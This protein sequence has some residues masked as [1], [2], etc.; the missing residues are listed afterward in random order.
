MNRLY[1]VESN[2][3]SFVVANGRVLMANGDVSKASIRVEDGRIASVAP[4][5]KAADMLDAAG[6]YVVPGLIDIHTHGIGREKAS[7][8]LRAYA[9]Q[10]AARG[11]TTFFPT[12]FGPPNETADHLRRHLK[13]TDLL[14]QVPQVGGFRLE[15]PYLA[16]AAGGLSRDLAPISQGLTDMLL[17][18]GEGHI[19]IWDV[20]PEMA[21]VPEA[22][23]YLTKQGIICSLA[24]TQATIDQARAA[25]DAGA[26]LVTHLFDTFVLPG[27]IDPDPG[28]YPAGL[29][30]YLLVEDRVVC[31]IIPDGTHV[32]PILVE[33]AFRCKPSA[34]LVFVT[35]SNY[36]AGLPPG[37][38]PLPGGW[39]LA[40]I[41]G[42]NNGVRLVD[43]KMG[44]CGSAL[45][46]I[47]CFRNAVKLFGK[48][49]GTASCVC[50]R[51]QSLLLGLNKGEIKAGRDADLLVLDKELNV[52]YTIV[53][54]QIIYRHGSTVHG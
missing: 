53:A 5:E 38:Y 3:S 23:R 4:H 6:A 34:G 49:F 15:S 42:P 46:P 25:V 13:E 35:D 37:E 24:H 33:K 39:G 18:A 8:D 29:I 20:S 43:R 45:T 41:N 44:L 17:K 7:G 36:G 47:D 28:V 22:I 52:L 21:G 26:R 48:D 12:F 14:R 27:G 19:R 51:N 32:D 9:A 40:K 31:E 30:D 10:E 1:E 50:S 16:A 54:G 11:T 2:S